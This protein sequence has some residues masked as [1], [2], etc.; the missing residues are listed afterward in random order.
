MLG[1]ASQV[2]ALRRVDPKDP[3]SARH[4]ISGFALFRR[5]PRRAGLNRATAFDEVH[6]QRVECSTRDTYLRP[7]V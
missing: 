7:R 2:S 3:R 5:T 4:S 6:S 1:S